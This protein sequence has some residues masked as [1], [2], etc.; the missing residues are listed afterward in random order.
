MGIMDNI[1]EAIDI[2]AQDVWILRI[3]S[4]AQ[5]H[6]VLA[7]IFAILCIYTVWVQYKIATTP[8]YEHH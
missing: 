2:F 6:P 4:M 7:T 1:R 5:H 3:V 8:V